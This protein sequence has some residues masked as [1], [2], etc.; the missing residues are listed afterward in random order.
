MHSRVDGGCSSAD[1]H[2]LVCDMLI[3]AASVNLMDIQLLEKLVRSTKGH[4]NERDGFDSIF[5]KECAI[6]VLPLYCLIASRRVASRRVY[7]LRCGLVSLPS[8]R[9]PL[10]V[11]A[12]SLVGSRSPEAKVSKFEVVQAKRAAKVLLDE[13]WLKQEASLRA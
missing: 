6:G 10:S 13:G 5:L 4:V 8:P 7:C 3:L 9:A 2:V 1:V 11:S 12:R